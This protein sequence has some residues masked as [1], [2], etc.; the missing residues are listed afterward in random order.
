MM[1]REEL[2]CRFLETRAIELEIGEVLVANDRPPAKLL[3]VDS[4]QSAIQG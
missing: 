2:T 3:A 4:L 1:Y